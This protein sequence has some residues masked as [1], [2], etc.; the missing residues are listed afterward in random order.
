MKTHILICQEL[1]LRCI[2]DLFYS[3]FLFDIFLMWLALK[4]EPECLGLSCAILNGIGVLESFPNG[5]GVE[6][7]I[8]SDLFLFF[9]GVEL[10]LGV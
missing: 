10:N 3:V 6:K 8:V 4:I 5:H 7:L 1:Q 2:C 9:L